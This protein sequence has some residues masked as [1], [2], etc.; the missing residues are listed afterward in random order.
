MKLTILLIIINVIIF[1]YTASNL[2]YYVNEYGFEPV[3]FLN[4]KY[5]TILTSIF[6]HA[7]L[8]HLFFNMLF[9]FL[10]GPTLE[11]NVS[12]LNFLLVYFLGG[13]VANLASFLPPFFR[14]GVPGVGASGAISALVGLGMFICPG[15]IIISQYLIPLPFVFVGAFYFLSNAMNLFIPSNIGYHVHMVGLIMGGMFGLY[16]S[17]NRIKGILI[18][19]ATLVLILFLPEILAFILALILS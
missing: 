3:S 18:F 4:G 19:I 1:I 15:K 7:N 14:P 12:E 10:L 2:N 8:I 16:W 5:H 13:M 9:L 17:E 6:L 11:K